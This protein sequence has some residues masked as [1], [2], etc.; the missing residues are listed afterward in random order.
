MDE[1]HHISHLPSQAERKLMK[2]ETRQGRAVNHIGTGKYA[3]FI[4]M[5]YL[6]Q[7]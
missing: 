5:V 3:A 4:L 1:K 7:Q 6:A 2:T